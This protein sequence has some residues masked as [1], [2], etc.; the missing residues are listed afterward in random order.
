MGG[1]ARTETLEDVL[2]AIS[3]TGSLRKAAEHLGMSPMWD[4]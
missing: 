4:L 2:K 3:Q 1:F